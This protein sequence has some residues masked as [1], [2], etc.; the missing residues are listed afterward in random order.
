MIST[1]RYLTVALATTAAVAL[2]FT[3]F[4]GL[5]LFV[6]GLFY[7]P[8]HGFVL[9]RTQLLLFLDGTMRP[10]LR[11]GAI[12]ASIFFLLKAV[13]ERPVHWDR[14]RRIYF[15]LTSVL[16]GPGLLVSVILKPHWGRARPI[17]TEPFGGEKLFT[18]P[19]QIADQCVG[20]CS[21]VS[22]DVSFF[23]AL[24]AIALLAR[25]TR[26]A[27]WVGVVAVLTALVILKRLAAGAHF[28]SDTL[29]ATLFPV[30]VVLLAYRW[31]LEGKG[32]ADWAA[33]R[34]PA[35]PL[36]DLAP[37]RSLKWRLWRVLVRIRRAWRRLVRWADT[38]AQR[39]S[40]MPAATPPA[41]VARPRKRRSQT[42]G[43]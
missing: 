31:M 41:A 27:F 32:P 2:I 28:F 16:L 30:L 5:D 8:A 22:G 13:S 29:F 10:L 33:L 23:A 14:S 19:L 4:P 40:R 42:A 1:G 26:R 12:A 15:V 9:E 18:P 25:P 17:Q 3:L 36:C 20:N 6:S 37:M 34:R 11:F 7:D 35:A 38:P 39:S 21:F 43:G 24:L